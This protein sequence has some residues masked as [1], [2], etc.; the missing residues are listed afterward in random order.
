MKRVFIFIQ[1]WR[2][3][4]YIT[5]LITMIVAVLMG[6][7]LREP[8]RKV[9][10]EQNTKDQSEQKKN[11]IWK[12]LMEP[13]VLLLFIAASIRHTGG[14]CFAY[15]SDR[16]FIYDILTYIYLYFKYFYIFLVYY[17]IYFPEVDLG[18]WLFAVTIG[19]G[20]HKKQLIAKRYYQIKL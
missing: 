4:Y 11:S 13:R 12:V 18:W 15:N 5:G 3:C 8:E 14:M 10:G 20:N 9:I 1:G 16:N 17:N 19:I 2:S 6:L 7:T